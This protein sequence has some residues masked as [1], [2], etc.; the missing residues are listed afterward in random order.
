MSINTTPKKILYVSRP[1]TPPWDE[2]SKNFAYNLAREVS[3]IDKLLEIHLMTSQIL[4]ELSQNIIQEKIYK[5]SQKDYKLS[6]KV[7]AIFFQYRNRESFNIKHYFFTPTPE[8][9]NLIKNFLK[10]NAKTI[11]TVATIRED[12]FT[13][14]QIEEMMFGDAI[15]TY[16]NYAKEKLEK[17]GLK[18]VS[19][20]YPGIDL[21]EY[22]P[23]EKSEEELKKANFKKEDFIINFSG[24]YIRLG[25]MDTVIDGFIE[26]SKKIPE[27]RLSLAVRVKNEKDALKKEEVIEKLTQENI[28]DK[29]S[30][31]DSGSYKMSDIYNLSDISIFPASNMKGKFDIPLA[32]IEAMACGKPVI[33][34]D[35]PILKEFS[36]ENNSVNIKKDSPQELAGAIIELYKNK[37]KR[38]TLGKNASQYVHE[39]FNIQKSAR[40]YT[41]IY[42]KL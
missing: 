40:E 6:D 25:A 17:L 33:I 41:E 8:S 32:V 2:A 7:R 13:D 16:S 19:K 21:N 5:F 31:H 12:I 37:E 9:S 26:V 29:V 42:N 27:A 20:I 14:N 34:S 38:E 1:I 22:S 28:L 10:G 15:V 18:N 39:N 4:P 24:E 36:N 11:Q 3:S 30:F 23:R 35:L